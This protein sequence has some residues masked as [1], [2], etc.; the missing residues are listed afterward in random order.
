MAINQ[1]IS[2]QHGKH[3]HKSA[4]TIS[5][6]HDNGVPDQKAQHNGITITNQATGFFQKLILKYLMKW[7]FR[8]IFTAGISKTGHFTITQHFSSTSGLIIS[9]P[10]KVLFVPRNVY[11]ME[12]VVSSV[13]M[14]TMINETTGPA[15]FIWKVIGMH[16]PNILMCKR[17]KKITK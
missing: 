11:G 7:G 1:Q 16:S 2:I 12:G 15:T 17:I 8:K 4:N 3:R 6:V 13:R 5:H 9:S 10:E 14:G